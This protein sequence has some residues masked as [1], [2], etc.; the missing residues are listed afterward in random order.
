M[1]VPAALEHRHRLPPHRRVLPLLAVVTARLLITL[2]PRQLRRVLELARSR[3]SLPTPDHHS[4]IAT[5]GTE[6]R[7]T[8]GEV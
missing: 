8:A 4:P 5:G 2:H 3:Q 6:R 7:S 1:S